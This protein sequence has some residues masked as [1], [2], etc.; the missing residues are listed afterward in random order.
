[1]LTTLFVAGIGVVLILALSWVLSM[2]G[3]KILGPERGPQWVRAIG[4]LTG[5]LL[6]LGAIV[7][8]IKLVVDVV[9]LVGGR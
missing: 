1:M 3:L 4:Q 6:G 8:G 9:A 7:T 5:M 2:T